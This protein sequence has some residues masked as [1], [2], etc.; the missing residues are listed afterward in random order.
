MASKYD[1]KVLLT[2]EIQIIR[3]VEENNKYGLDPFYLIYLFSHD[4]TQKQLYNKVMIDTTLP[5]IGDRRKELYLPISTDKN[6]I[7]RIKE[8]VSNAFEKK[9]EAIDNITRLKNEF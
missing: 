8:K 2:K 3:V 5:N 1:T 4:I 9:W 7:K 6:E